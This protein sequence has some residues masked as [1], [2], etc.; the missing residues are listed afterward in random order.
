MPENAGSRLR[1]MVD[2]PLPSLVKNDYGVQAFSA[3]VLD[4]SLSKTVEFL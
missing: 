1:T 3:D 2:A 4:Q